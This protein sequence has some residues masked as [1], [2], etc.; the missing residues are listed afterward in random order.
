MERREN[1]IIRL[2][3]GRL[4]SPSLDDSLSFILSSKPLFNLRNIK[5]KK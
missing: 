5:K 2:P 4:F 3:A 1:K